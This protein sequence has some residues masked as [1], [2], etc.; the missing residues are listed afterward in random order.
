MSLS[1]FVRFVVAIETDAS[2]CRSAGFSFS[3]L[4]GGGGFCFFAGLLGFVDR[5][6][7][8]SIVV[9]VPKCELDGWVREEML[10]LLRLWE[11][12]GEVGLLLPGSG[13]PMSRGG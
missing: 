8:P 7:G 3:R 4:N 9:V 12:V 11:E 2:A 13:L 5:E 6:F 10:L 1:E